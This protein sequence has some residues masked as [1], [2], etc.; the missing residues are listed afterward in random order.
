MNDTT[1]KRIRFG[2]GQL[3]FVIAAVFFLAAALKAYQLAMTP[4]P[5]PVHRSIFTPLLE[6]LN[7]RD[8]LMFVVEVE[9]LFALILLS[10]IQQQWICWLISLLCF[11]TFSA[12]SIMKGLSGEKSC[13]CFG[14]VTVNPWITASFD[15]II[16][17]LLAFFRE[18]FKLNLGI[19]TSDRK[20]LTI[21]LAVWF[22]LTI[23]V[24]FAMLSLKQQV[25]AMLGTEF[26]G[27]DNRMIQLEPENW[28]GKEFP[29]AS[30]FVQPANYE[31]LK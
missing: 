11:T 25:H 24:L 7:N 29:L 16:V 17:I 15:I 14:V 18:P 6:L 4:L 3:R 5:S 1:Q 2:F 8:L 12:I 30:R 28:I 23:P 22:F 27:S 20:K 19:S 26:T 10:G 9:I 31:M 21:V 13:G